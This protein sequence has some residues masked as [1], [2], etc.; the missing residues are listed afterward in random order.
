MKEHEAAER[1]PAP[2]GAARSGS[3][4]AKPRKTESGAKAKGR[5]PPAT[6]A[7]KMKRLPAPRGAARSGSF[8]AKP[9]KTESGACLKELLAHRFRLST[10]PV[11]LPFVIRETARKY[12]HSVSQMTVWEQV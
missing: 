6:E 5:R 8:V 4:V 10:E 12:Q 1:L 9:R 11:D 3:F 7:E 2:R